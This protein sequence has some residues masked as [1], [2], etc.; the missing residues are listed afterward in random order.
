MAEMQAASLTGSQDSNPDP[1]KS[2]DLVRFL[3]DSQAILGLKKPAKLDKP[4]NPRELF[5]RRKQRQ[6]ISNQH[7]KLLPQTTNLSRPRG[8][9]RTSSVNKA[10]H[11]VTREMASVFQTGMHRTLQHT[12]HVSIDD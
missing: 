10:E 7:F 5:S 11:M 1:L 9:Q 2:P 6:Q 12:R 8:G 4:V 3:K